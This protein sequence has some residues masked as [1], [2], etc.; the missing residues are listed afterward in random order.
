[1]EAWLASDGHRVNLEHPQYTLTG[2]G[3][4]QSATGRLYWAQDFGAPA[5]DLPPLPL[6]PGPDGGSSLPGA[7]TPRTPGG[8][9]REDALTDAAGKV[10][11]RTCRRSRRSRRTA[12]CR[13]TLHAGP[14]TVR[15]RL[16]R[17]HRVLA[18]G[19]VHAR[20][21]GAVRLRLRSRGT[22][23]PGRTLL[24]LR[25]GDARLRRVVQLR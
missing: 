15:A 12:I 5:V 8:T 1:V 24:R 25:I 7:G 9:D 22:L 18:R 16:L 14:V 13:L 2:V 20:S 17:D 4:A 3:V 23:T 11:V 19:V 10:A 6:P 21:A